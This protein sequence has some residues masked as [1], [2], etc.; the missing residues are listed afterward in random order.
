MTLQERNNAPLSHEGE[1]GVWLSTGAGAD[2]GGSGYGVGMMSLG[3]RSVEVETLEQRIEGR[4]REALE[5]MVAT[6]RYAWADDDRGLCARP[7]GSG[8]PFIYLSIGDVSRI[9]AAEARAWF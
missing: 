3:S 5:R 7:P 8:G 1:R 6:E 9:A 4:L 2:V